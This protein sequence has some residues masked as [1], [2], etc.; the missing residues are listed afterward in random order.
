MFQPSVPNAKKL[1]ITEHK[2]RIRGHRRGC[3]KFNQ[4]NYY[5]NNCTLNRIECL[6]N[7]RKRRDNFRFDQYQISMHTEHRRN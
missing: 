1:L 3:D 2:V 5:N 7:S 4:N 6:T